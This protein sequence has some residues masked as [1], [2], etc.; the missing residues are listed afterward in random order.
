MPVNEV[1]VKGF[2]LHFLEVCLQIVSTTM[3]HHAGGA[4]IPPGGEGVRS[5]CQG[6]RWVDGHCETR[7][8]NVNHCLDT[9]KGLQ[10]RKIGFYIA[11]DGINDEL[12]LFA[13]HNIWKFSMN[14]VSKM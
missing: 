6:C 5:T 4:G 11:V 7:H 10:R 3:H 9:V 12:V 1:V 13:M 14:G 8:I 2:F